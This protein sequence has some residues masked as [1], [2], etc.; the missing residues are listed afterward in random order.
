[1]EPDFSGRDLRREGGEQGQAQ[2]ESP[3]AVVRL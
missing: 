1:M 3:D 2:K